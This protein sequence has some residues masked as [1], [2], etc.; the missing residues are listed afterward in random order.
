MTLESCASDCAGY[1]YFGV[2]YGRECKHSSLIFSSDTDFVPEVIVETA[3]QLGQ[4]LLLLVIVLLRVL[5]IQLSFVGLGTVFRCT[6]KVPELGP[7]RREV[8]VEEQL[9]RP[10]RL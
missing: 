4:L 8:A 9:P 6:R 2:E 5:E 10:P 1:T 7:Q 3:S